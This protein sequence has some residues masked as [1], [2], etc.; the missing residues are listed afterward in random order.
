[1]SSNTRAN[2][3]GLRRDLLVSHPSTD[4][5]KT[6]LSF[7]CDKQSIE[8]SNVVKSSV[9]LLNYCIPA[10][11]AVLSFYGDL[12]KE[13]T[14]YYWTLKK[15]TVT[16]NGLSQHKVKIDHV[17]P[18]TKRFYETAKLKLADERDTSSPPTMQ[19]PSLPSPTKAIQTIEASPASPTASQGCSSPESPKVIPT[20]PR[21]IPMS[22]RA[23]SC[24]SND[25]EQTPMSPTNLDDDTNHNENVQNDT[26]ASSVDIFPELMDL[27]GMIQRAFA[28]IVEKH[29]H[30]ESEVT[31]GTSS[32]DRWRVRLRV[33][34]NWAA[35]M[36]LQFNINYSATASQLATELSKSKPSA[37]LA[38]EIDLWLANPV[39]KL[40]VDLILEYPSDIKS[41]FNRIVSSS[42]SSDWLLTYILLE[43]SKRP[44]YDHNFP[45][46]MGNIIGSQSVLDLISQ[47]LVDALCAIR[48]DVVSVAQL[49]KLCCNSLERVDHSRICISTKH[50]LCMS[51]T[52]CYFLLLEC[53]SNNQGEILSYIRMSLTCMTLLK[54]STVASHILCRALLERSLV[55]GHL[56]NYNFDP[57]MIRD[58]TALSELNGEDM[59][60]LSKENLKA[61]LGHRFRRLPNRVVDRTNSKKKTQKV[62]SDSNEPDKQSINSYLLTE[63]FKSS[64]NRVEDFASLFVEFHCPVMFDKH[65]WPNDDALR[66]INERN[67][68]ILRKFEQVPTMWDLYEFIG[69]SGCLKSCL[70]LIKALLAAHLALWASATNKSA[71]DK[72]Q[73]TS[74]L[75]PPLAKSGLIPRAFGLSVEVLPH[76]ASGEVFSV[77]SD[78][79]HYLKDTNSCGVNLAE[80][81]DE[82]RRINSKVY[83]NRLRLFMCQHTPGPLYVTIFKEFQKPITNN[84]STCQS[85][86]NN[87]QD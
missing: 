7:V 64:I 24:E 3:Q 46:C 65:T 27:I 4:H 45:S 53:E 32:Q 2:Q 87:N 21:V 41:F 63:A 44:N 17:G 8:M 28:R 43:M 18:L 56:F 70:V 34:T 48:F 25:V 38:T 1:M 31:S 85:N 76:L 23:S 9:E 12:F 71:P 79:W 16:S 73:S 86:D 74:R 47:M 11:D 84:K 40:L 22:R 29:K 42:K 81:S 83:L 52:T 60:K 62:T 35:E 72:I 78:I 19:P 15:K 20:G 66:V 67:L 13:Y 30:T 54:Q 37:L 26:S 61:T 5:L 59:I 33:I 36:L 68:S 39:N 6:F 82:E 69:D 80:L 77:L 58:E 55:Y 75:I 14:S 51:L 57:D 10:R 50:R 49:I